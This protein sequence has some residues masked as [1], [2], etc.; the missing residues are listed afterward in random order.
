MA[1]LT[2]FGTES[3]D[4][5]PHFKGGQT[6]NTSTDMNSLYKMISCWERNTSK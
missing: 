6:N 4:M 5:E 2:E 1:R 3:I